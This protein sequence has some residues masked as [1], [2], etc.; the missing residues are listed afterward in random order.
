MIREFRSPHELDRL[1]VMRSRFVGIISID[2]RMI[3][4]A[5]NTYELLYYSA[6]FLKL[7][8]AV[9]LCVASFKVFAQQIISVVNCRSYVA[10]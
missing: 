7:C 10:Y 8:S 1:N 4:S 5:S 2:G 9:Q 3:L 6:A